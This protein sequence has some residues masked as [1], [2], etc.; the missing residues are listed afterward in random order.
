L[1]AQVLEQGAKHLHDEEM[2]DQLQPNE[3]PQA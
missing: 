2:L 1:G 3:M